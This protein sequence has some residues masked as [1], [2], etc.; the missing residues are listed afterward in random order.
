MS[1]NPLLSAWTGP[2]GLPPF[3]AIRAEHVEPAFD[4]A[5]AAH[6]AELDAIATNPA[7][8][9]FDNTLAALDRAGRALTALEHLFS[10]LSASAS[11]PELQA[12][13]RRM[14][15]PLAAHTNAIYLNA[16]LFE[17]VE[18][19]HEQRASLG[20]PA[21]SLRLLERVHLDFVRAGARLQGE[22]ARVTPRSWSG[23][24]NSTPASRRT[25][26]PTKA[27]TGWCCAARPNW[28]G[29]R[30]SSAPPRGRPRWN[31][32]RWRRACTS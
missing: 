11:S 25:C 12:V 7:A 17:R 20:L 30:T 22:G 1:T 14:A 9:D 32:G 31:A 21:E 6:R 18:R 29:C 5:L 10:T 23:R 19:L 15:A 2:Y 16:A 28:P 3:D 13:Q 26:S 4:A 27:A 24:P 8:P